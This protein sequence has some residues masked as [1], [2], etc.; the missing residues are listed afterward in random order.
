MATCLDIAVSRTDLLNWSIM[1]FIPDE[2]EETKVNTMADSALTDAVSDFWRDYFVRIREYANQSQ[3]YYKGLIG[4]KSYSTDR[5]FSSDYLGVIFKSNGLK[6]TKLYLNRIG[7]MV[8]ESKTIT[9]SLYKGPSEGENVEHVEDFNVTTT[10]NSLSWSTVLTDKVYDFYEDGCGVWYYLV[11]N[12]TTEKPKDNKIHCGCGGR[13]GQELREIK[14]YTTVYGIQGD[15]LTKLEDWNRSDSANGFVLDIELKCD[16]ENLVCLNYD[17]QT[18]FTRT[19]KEAIMYKAGSLFIQQVLD[20]PNIERLM[21]VEREHLYGK[22]NSF[23]KSYGERIEWLAMEGTN[24]EL[25]DCYT[26]KGMMRTVPA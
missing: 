19:T 14:K 12:P 13:K 16:D 15:D 24:Y 26:C 17:E 22:R 25:N 20:N 11:M 7:L 2:T 10:A 3:A 21:L 4:E 23:E 18:N 1:Q 5:S 8:N 9:V 6:D